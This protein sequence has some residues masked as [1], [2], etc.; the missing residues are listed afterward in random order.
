MRSLFQVIGLVFSEVDRLVPVVHI[1]L[2]DDVGVYDGVSARLDATVVI[3]AKRLSCL[4]HSLEL[5]Q[6]PGARLLLLRVQ[7]G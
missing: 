2:A 7:L 1:A 3:L 6:L 5:L 4:G